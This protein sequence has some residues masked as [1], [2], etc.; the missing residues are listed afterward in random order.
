MEAIC[1]SETLVDI[2]QT[3][4]HYVPD[5]N[6]RRENLKS[7]VYEISSFTIE[8]LMH[9]DGQM[10]L[11]KH[12]NIFMDTEKCVNPS[13]SH[14]SFSDSTFLYCICEVSDEFAVSLVLS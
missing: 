7:Y 8:A 12:F 2:Q 11:K 5:N 9:T 6:N 1:C 10:A 13:I 4:Q 3:A 14:D